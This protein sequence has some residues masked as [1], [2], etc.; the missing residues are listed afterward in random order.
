MIA[1]FLVFF[2]LPLSPS[3]FR[4]I[5]VSVVFGFLSTVRRFLLFCVCSLR[6]FTF[7]ASLLFQISSRR[8]LVSSVGCFTIVTCLIAAPNPERRNL[9][10]GDVEKQ[11]VHNIKTK[12]KRTITLVFSFLFFFFKKWLWNKGEGNEEEKTS[13]TFYDISDA[14]VSVLVHEKRINRS[15]ANVCH[16]N[17]LIGFN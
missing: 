10:W 15:R 13:F 16:E 14:W 5:S 2:S 7:F 17:F 11:D 4:S 12:K 1:H 8:V 6:S 3:H 9:F